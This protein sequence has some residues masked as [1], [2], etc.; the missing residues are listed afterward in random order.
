MPEIFI[1]EELVP[2]FKAIIKL[3]KKATQKIADYLSNSKIFNDPNIFLSDLDKFIEKDLKI[4]ESR[5]IVQAIGSFID[6]L[7]DDTCEKVSENL[8][9]SFKELHYN[10]INDKD[11]SLLKN[12]LEVILSS[13]HNLEISI[14]AYRLTRES[15][16]VYRKSKVLSDI[17]VVF[18]KELDNKNRKAVLVHNLHLQ[19][20]NNS[21]NKEFFVALDLEDLK[22]IKEK[23]DRAIR[24]DEIIKNDYKIFDLI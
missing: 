1:S 11:L 6:L 17:R 14:K 16:N 8:A 15:S 12:N 5:S 13:A 10:D 9:N 3:P 18:E 4:K 19:Y 2:G 7:Q 22:E 23:I 21:E 24:K 20:S